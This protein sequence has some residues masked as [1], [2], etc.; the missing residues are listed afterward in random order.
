MCFMA[1]PGRWATFGGAA[2]A[3]QSILQEETT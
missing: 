2:C 1:M 3:I